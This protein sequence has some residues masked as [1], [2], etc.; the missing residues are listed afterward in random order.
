MFDKDAVDSWLIAGWVKANI[1]ITEITKKIEVQQITRL[2]IF[3]SPF[4]WFYSYCR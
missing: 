1:P 3:L 4:A 2:R